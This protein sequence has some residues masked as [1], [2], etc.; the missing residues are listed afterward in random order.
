MDARKRGDPRATM[1]SAMMALSGPPPDGPNGRLRGPGRNSGACLWDAP[2]GVAGYPTDY[3]GQAGLEGY[4]SHYHSPSAQYGASGWMMH[5]GQGGSVTY[6]FRGSHGG[7]GLYGR[8]SYFSQASGG[9]TSATDHGGFAGSQGG[10]GPMRL[11]Y[12]HR[13]WAPYGSGYGA[14]RGRG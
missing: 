11:S 14:N 6:G 5:G 9:W 2:Y 12:Q 8:N 1:V 3:S 4:P 13:S 10:A 7:S